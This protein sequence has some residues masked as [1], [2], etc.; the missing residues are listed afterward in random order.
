MRLEMTTLDD[1][2]STR[3]KL[4]RAI[5]QI[6]AERQMLVL[7]VEREIGNHAG[8]LKWLLQRVQQPK[9]GWRG[10]HGQYVFPKASLNEVSETQ[11]LH[12]IEGLVGAIR[13]CDEVLELLHEVYSRPKSA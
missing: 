7:K 6:Q 1:T 8:G 12:R 11:N 9:K 10:I 4:R 3:G 5:L 13:M 2:H